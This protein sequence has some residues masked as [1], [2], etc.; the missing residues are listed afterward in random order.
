MQLNVDN[1]PLNSDMK[2]LTDRIVATINSNAA[3]SA[4]AADAV[5]SKANAVRTDFSLYG[6]TRH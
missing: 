2:M 4:T 5:D 6:L 3:A 1:A